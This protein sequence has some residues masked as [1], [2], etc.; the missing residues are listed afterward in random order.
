[1]NLLA[2]SDIYAADRRHEY[3]VDDL[4]PFFV[5]ATGLPVPAPHA[6]VLKPA[7]GGRKAPSLSYSLVPGSGYSLV[8]QRFDA[9]GNRR[10][11]MMSVHDPRR[12]DDWT[13]N[14]DQSVFP[15]GSLVPGETA[16]KVVADFA[17][18]PDI[19]SGAV[20]WVDVTALNWP[21]P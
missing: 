17:G 3:S 12:M 14:P 19:L 4:A 15:A 5:G 9:E 11:T 8:W 6:D 2:T 20:E 7:P 13:Q 16:I 10:P 21:D 18:N 1:M